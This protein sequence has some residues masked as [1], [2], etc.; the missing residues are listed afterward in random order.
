M[1]DDSPASAS[2]DAPDAPPSNGVSS[3][4]DASQQAAY[5]PAAQSA[6]ERP[7]R[8]LLP[9]GY[10]GLTLL[11][12]AGLTVVGLLVAGQ[13]W[14]GDLANSR[15]TIAAT[16]LDLAAPRN[17]SAWFAAMLTA[18]AGLVALYLYSLRRHRVDDYHNRYRVWLWTAVACFAVSFG[19]TTSAASA[20]RM[21]CDVAAT[22]CN[23]DSRVVWPALLAALVALAVVRLL[24]EVGRSRGSAAL[25]AIS[26]VAFGVAAAVYHGWIVALDAPMRTVVG[27]GSW[28]VGYV[29]LLVGFLTI[30]RYV[31]LEI[32]GT[33]AVKPWSQKPARR[34]RKKGF[35]RSESKAR[36][37]KRRTAAPNDSESVP[38]QSNVTAEASNGSTSQVRRDNGSPK[39][40]G[41]KGPQPE[42]RSNGHSPSGKVEAATGGS[43]NSGH[44]DSANDSDG[45]NRKLSRKERRR[46]RREAR[47]N[48]QQA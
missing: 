25:V 24:F 32:D 10:M 1:G 13:L 28:L 5:A 17:A 45:P 15:S 12:A 4:D 14:I 2:G 46:L 23:L 22:A 30:A 19:E 18:S 43:G 41:P 42:A 33:I 34:R 36:R 40:R 21:V 29:L 37:G 35:E 9:A 47:R 11:T 26:G 38:R 6:L 48:A 44:A 20:A 3:A 31:A 7:L 27:R 16:L 39:T 8:E